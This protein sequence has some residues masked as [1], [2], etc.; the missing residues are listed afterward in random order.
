MKA[1][2]NSVDRGVLMK[3]LRERGIREGLVKKVE[4]VL[5]KTISRVRVGGEEGENFWTARRVRQRC[6]MTFL[7]I[8]IMLADLEEEMGKVKW[9]RVKIRSDRVYTLSYADDVV[10]LAEEE[11]DMRTMIERL[12]GYLERKRL[13]LNV[14]KSKIVRFKRGC[15]RMMRV[16]WWW[17]GQG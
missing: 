11:G 13:E 7:L 4:E 3:T 6:I 17:K 2:L 8:N 5:R 10:L 15:K 12:E 16:N 9:G 14:G 1:A